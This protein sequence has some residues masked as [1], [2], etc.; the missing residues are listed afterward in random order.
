MANK[1]I[2]VCVPQL[3]LTKYITPYLEQMD[4][5]RWY[6]N[7]GPLV[8]EFLARIADLFN[9]TRSQVI[10]ATNGTVMLE[11]CLKAMEIPNDSFCIM[12]S[13]TFVATPLAAVNA[14]LQPYFVDVELESQTI[15]PLKLEAAIPQIA[16]QGKIGAVIVVTPFGMPVSV[17]AWDDFTSRTGIPVIIDAAAGFDSALQMPEMEVGQ[18]P[19]M[20]SLHATKVMG[21]GE[22]AIL[23]SQNDCLVRQ[24]ECL[25][26]FGFPR[27][28]RNAECFGTNAKISEYVGAVGLAALDT[29]CET[30][31]AWKLISDYYQKCLN[32]AGIQHTLANDWVPSTC[33][34]ILPH[35]ADDAVLK[36]EENSI[37]A[38]KW[39]GDGCHHQ[40]VF[41]NAHSGDLSNTEFLAKSVVGLPFYIGME[42]KAIDQVIELMMIKIESESMKIHATKR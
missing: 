41:K 26:Q 36:L 2:P 30:R 1:L 4:A 27:G 35:Q 28:I 11:L 12:P 9:L 3:P 6:T 15:D 37:M 14:N 8:C 7:Y 23:L 31:N 25:T 32:D 20:I 16:A 18:T 19:M 33:N 21:V 40:S 22:G 42:T 10:S 5:N 34:I 38:R 24:I 29:W 17:K 13:W 39:Y